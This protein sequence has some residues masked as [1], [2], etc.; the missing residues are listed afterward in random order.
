MKKLLLVPVLII[1]A[2]GCLA[3]CGS[4]NDDSLEVTDAWTRVTA[5]GQD[6]GA[7]YMT[8]KSPDDDKLIK[9]SVPASVA[10]K[11]ELHETVH[12]DSA[13]SESMDS[14]GSE[15]MDA[16]GSD[17]M[18]NSSSE[19]MNS[20]DAMMGMR[21]V[22]SIDLPAGEDVVLE[23]GGYHIMLHHPRRALAAGMSVK[24]E[25]R[26]ESGTRLTVVAPVRRAES[27]SAH[28]H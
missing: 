17:S 13:D 14:S 26:F 15:S 22:D 9:A 25:L 6:S 5:P 19:S 18:E 24:L 12:S 16:S 4:S 8:I 28:H 1:A 23:P 21:H 27:G 2:A 11:T 20:G 3:A 7:V 10:G